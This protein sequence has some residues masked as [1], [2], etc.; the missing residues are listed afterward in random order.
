MG[1]VERHI[2]L[3][4][5]HILTVPVNKPNTVINAP[6]APYIVPYIDRR[7]VLVSKKSIWCTK[8]A[9]FQTINCNA[10]YLPAST[11]SIPNSSLKNKVNINANEK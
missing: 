6:H 1:R 7:D 4:Y 9:T 8:H 5:T 3:A 2:P 11:S 10:D